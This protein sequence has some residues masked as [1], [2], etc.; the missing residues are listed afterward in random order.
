[1]ED[2]TTQVATV[3]ASVTARATLA[4]A[5]KLIA[6][7]ITLCAM[8]LWTTGHITWS[9]WPTIGLGL[10][11]ASLLADWMVADDAERRFATRQPLLNNR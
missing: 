9:I 4:K 1:M 3:P 5:V 7:A 6:T 11:L 2:L 10:G 8:D